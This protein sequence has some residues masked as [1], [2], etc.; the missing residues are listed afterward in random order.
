MLRILSFARGK[1][2]V[3]YKIKS[4][5]FIIAPE[6][7]AVMLNFFYEHSERIWRM[8][9]M[10]RL[11]KSSYREIFCISGVFADPEVEKTLQSGVS[12]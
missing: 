11:L 8:E 6:L 5:K 2:C 1:D 9:N 3:R 7:K 12:N 4:K 10:T